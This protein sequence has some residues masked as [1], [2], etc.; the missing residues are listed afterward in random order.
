MAT[1]PA[2]HGAAA[3]SGGQEALVEVGDGPAAGTITVRA[4]IA[5][6]LRFQ[7][8]IPSIARSGAAAPPPDRS[9]HRL[10]L[11]ADLGQ[12]VLPPRGPGMYGYEFTCGAGVL[13]GQLVVERT[14]PARAVARRATLP[15][16]GLAVRCSIVRVSAQRGSSVSSSTSSKVNPASSIADRVSRFGWQPPPRRD[17]TGAHR[18]CRPGEPAGAAYVLE[19]GELAARFERPPRLGQRGIRVRDRA[20]R[21]R[22][23]DCVER[24]VG[25]G[26]RLRARVP[27]LD[28][29]HRLIQFAV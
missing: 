9:V 12:V 27:H 28:R 3:A 14:E 26:Q 16:R 29:C 23:G 21:E 17:H 15:Y 2:A 20:Q 8:R 11:A 7:R 18:S 4:N 10:V 25:K 19:H 22:E 13:R 24:G 6:R 1:A 5:V